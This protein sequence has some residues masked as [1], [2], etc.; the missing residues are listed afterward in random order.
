MNGL[1]YTLNLVFVTPRSAELSLTGTADAKVLNQETLE[2]A[3]PFR[4]EDSRGTP[5]FYRGGLQ[6]RGC[7]VQV[8]YR[9]QI[10]SINVA[11]RQIA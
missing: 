11:C 10:V 6:R 9:T 5:A 8:S 3:Y 4:I 7:L 2:T 1:I